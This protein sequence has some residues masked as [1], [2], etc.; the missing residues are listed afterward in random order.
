MQASWKCCTAF[1][2]SKDR[3]G[4][5]EIYKLKKI[6]R[7]GEGKLHKKSIAID[8]FSGAG[9]F[10]IGFEKEGFTIALAI[11]NDPSVNPSTTKQTKR[12]N[13]AGEEES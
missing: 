12:V 3:N 7:S 2:S 11:D 13:E 1:P 6:N 8:F 10:H 9:G 5:K 4:I